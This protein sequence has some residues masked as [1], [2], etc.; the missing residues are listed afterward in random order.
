MGCFGCLLGL[1]FLGIPIFFGRMFW[2]FV[3]NGFSFGSKTQN[4]SEIPDDSKNFILQIDENSTNPW[5]KR[6]KE[7]P[8]YGQ[9]PENIAELMNRVTPDQNEKVISSIWTSHGMTHQGYLVIT[10][11]YLRWIQV[12]PS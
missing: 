3:G 7:S 5:L 1:L 10:H 9:V 12:L 2:K 4:L 11:L 6:I 8:M